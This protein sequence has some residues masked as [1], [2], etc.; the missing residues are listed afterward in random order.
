MD[1]EAEQLRACKML[2]IEWCKQQAINDGRQPPDDDVILIALHKSRYEWPD[3]PAE[4]RHASG[5]W[6]RENRYKRLFGADVLP[7]GEL[8]K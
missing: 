4:L 6:L 1:K 8:P 5:H 2:D 7:E 3:V